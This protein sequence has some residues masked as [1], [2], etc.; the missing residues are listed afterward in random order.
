MSNLLKHA[1]SELTK[2]GL[3]NKDSDYE[4]E[5][6]KAVMELM[7]AFSR[8]GHSEASAHMTLDVFSKLAKF[9]NL[10]PLTDDPSEWV[11]TH[12][13]TYQNKRCSEA[14]S[15]DGG[16]TYYLLS[17]RM[18]VYGCQVCDS[19]WQSHSPQP[20]VCSCGRKEVVKKPP[21]DIVHH[22]LP[23]SGQLQ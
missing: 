3:F 17:E 16:K 9:Q 5:I 18:G 4:G 10:T 8:Q 22:S 11:N 15:E 21:E 13:N 12:D 14:F 19:W 23:H 2:S 7:V 20:G 6:G 1:E